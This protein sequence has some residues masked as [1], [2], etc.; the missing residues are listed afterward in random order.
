MLRLSADERGRALGLIEAGVPVVNV[1]RTIQVIFL[2]D[3]AQAHRAMETQ[4]YLAGKQIDVIHPGPIVLPDMYPIEYIWD[5]L[6]S[7]Q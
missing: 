3:N 1:A 7:S 6:G 5:I 2:Q 4:A